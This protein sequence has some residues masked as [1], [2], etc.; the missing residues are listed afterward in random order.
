M[1]GGDKHEYVNL[2]NQFLVAMPTLMDPNFHRTVTYICEHSA[3]GAMGIVVNRPLDIE[4]GEIMAQMD[5]EAGSALGGVHA[6]YGGPV[7]MARGFVLHTPIGEWEAT[8][9]IAE[10]IGVTS[11]R[12][13]LM[14]MA[15]GA[16][17]DKAIVALGY[18]GWGA[19]QLESELAQNAWL[20]CP[21]NVDIMFDTDCER[22]LEAAAADLGVDLNSLTT[23]A[24]HA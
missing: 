7:D 14:A 18:S 21:A 17:P 9:K 24:G 15:R 6:Y 5:I 20:T 10:G 13:I 23:S 3:E 8:L 4:L 1:T 22:K 2:T 12:D 11:S 19:G 16:G